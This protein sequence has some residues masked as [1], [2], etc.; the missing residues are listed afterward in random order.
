MTK[1]QV[2]AIG[3]K[4]LGLY[5][6]INGTALGLSN[7][8][9]LLYTV[10]ENMSENGPMYSNFWPGLLSNTLTQLVLIIC[11][12]VLIAKSKSIDGNDP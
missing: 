11:G 6:V 2:H 1:N 5:F 12:I 10:S 9:Y 4:L 3:M 7:V 8:L